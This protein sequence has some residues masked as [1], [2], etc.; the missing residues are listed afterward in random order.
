MKLDYSDMFYPVMGYE[1]SDH[2]QV[3]AMP[4]F[5]GIEINRIHARRLVPTIK[6]LSLL[7]G[8]GSPL[9]ERYSEL[10]KRREKALQLSGLNTKNKEYLDEVKSLDN[11]D[12]VAI[13]AQMLRKQGEHELSLLLTQEHF[14]HELTSSMLDTIIADDDKDKMMALKRKAELSSMMEDVVGRINKFRSRYFKDDKIL[15][16]K[17]RRISGF[18]PE[19]MANIGK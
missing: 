17:V 6:Y 16:K 2:E 18:Y 3:L 19:A 4:E 1:N 15:E 10:E 7:Y 8:K 11:D 5:E 9:I 12:L 13:V 14:M